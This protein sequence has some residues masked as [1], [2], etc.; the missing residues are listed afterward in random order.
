MYREPIVAEV[1][2]VRVAHAAQFGYGSKAT[3]QALE[4]QEQKAQCATVS[5]PAK[6]ISAEEQPTNQVS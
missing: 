4:E 3:C 5:L 2:R 1:R 6:C